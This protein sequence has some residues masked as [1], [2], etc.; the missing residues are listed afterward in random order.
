MIKEKE[1]I[2]ELITNQLLC[3]T[4]IAGRTVQLL[5]T[6]DDADDQS[7]TAEFA[8]TDD[9]LRRVRTLRFY[10]FVEG[11]KTFVMC[12]EDRDQHITMNEKLG[13][14]DLTSSDEELKKFIL[15]FL[16]SW[17]WGIPKD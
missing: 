12:C 14:P 10:L 2:F 6:V 1:R 3:L 5:K 11:R 4:D 7:F 17:T 8:V 15:G 16:T 9:G 13:S